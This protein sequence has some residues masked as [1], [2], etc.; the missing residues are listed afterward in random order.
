MENSGLKRSLT[1]VTVFTLITGAMVGM[2]WAVLPNILFGY[3]GP[4]L[5]LSVVIAAAF[6]MFIG[7]CYAELCAAMPFAG[8]EYHYTKVAMGKFFSFIT[9]WFLVVAYSVMMPGEI[10]IL[11]KVLAMLITSIP[12]WLIG[13]ILALIFGGINLI[14]I[15]IS[16]VLQFVF[17][18]VLFL[19]MAIFIFGGWGNIHWENFTPFFDGHVGGMLMMVPIGMLAF[20]GFDIVPQAAEEVKSPINK[21]VYM[22]PLSIAFVCFFYVGAFFTAAGNMPPAQIAQIKAEVPLI[23]VAKLFLGDTGAMIILVAGIMGLITTLNAFVI[24]ASRLMLGMA[25]EGVLP[26]SLAK[27]SQKYGTPYWAIILIT[28]F[29]ILGAIFQQLFMVFQIAS[30]AIL[31]AFI[32]VIISFII[33]RKK[34][35]DM[36]RPYV[37]PLYP[38]TPIIALFGSIAAFLFSLISFESWIHWVIFG[39]ATILGLFY[40]VSRVKNREL[41][42]TMT[43]LS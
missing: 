22:I 21:V 15:R 16:A 29:G 35:P 36:E 9:G 26:E 6:C 18:L 32:L 40:Y 41:K 34:R 39:A 7:L 1:L 17:S 25:R 13:I 12:K 38:L 27:V 37:V 8:G 4:A 20:M 19:G 5:L 24:G 30:S 10:I 28:F 42:E 2:A 31:I 14:G 3:A 43:N 11:S 33:L 23:E